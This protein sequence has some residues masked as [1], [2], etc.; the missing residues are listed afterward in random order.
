MTHDAHHERE[1]SG[2]ACLDAGNG[3]VVLRQRYLGV[4]NTADGRDLLVVA[5]GNSA[6]D[7][8]PHERIDSER[9]G[10]LVYPRET[11]G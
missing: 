8:Y 5:E 10:Y 6:F 9:V 4:Y 11:S 1:A 7:V 2:S 3:E